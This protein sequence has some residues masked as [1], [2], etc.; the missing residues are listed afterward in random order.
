MS[1]SFYSIPRH[2]LGAVLVCLS[3]AAVTA[4][5]GGSDD[6]IP[7][8]GANSQTM[9]LGAFAYGQSGSTFNVGSTANAAT[10]EAANDRAMK[11]CGRTY[12]AVV[13]EFNDCG[14]FVVGKNASGSFVWGTASGPS[15]SAAQKAAETSCAGKGGLGCQLGNMKPICNVS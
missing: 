15:A 13:M 11:A 9:K 7:D 3:V 1:P 10:Q 5:G 6:N 2:W 4:C 8:E 14:A 12:C